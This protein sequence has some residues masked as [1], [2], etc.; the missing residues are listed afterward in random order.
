L[1]PQFFI[2]QER[3]KASQSE[4]N[5]K[6]LTLLGQKACNAFGQKN[7]CNV[8]KLEWKEACNTFKLAE[9]IAV[10]TSAARDNYRSDE[11]C[12]YN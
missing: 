3:R 12:K 11:C 1:L 5:S 2:A 9:M 4:H 7:T 10:A 6:V 8:S